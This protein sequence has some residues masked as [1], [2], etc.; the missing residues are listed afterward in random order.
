M[1]YC[2]FIRIPVCRRPPLCLKRLQSYRSYSLPSFSTFVFTFATLPGLADAMKVGNL[3]LMLTKS[4]QCHHGTSFTVSHGGCVTY[5][6]AVQSL[7]QALKTVY[8]AFR[9]PKGHASVFQC[10]A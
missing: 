3:T 1:C 10:W 7:S 5:A 9:A 6:P 4:V 2:T 8:H